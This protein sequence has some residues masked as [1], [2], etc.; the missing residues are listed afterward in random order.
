MLDFVRS[1]TGHIGSFHTVFSLKN[2]NNA[3][4]KVGVTLFITE[5]TFVTIHLTPYSCK[6]IQEDK[7]AR[8]EEK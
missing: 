3:L 5:H 1:Y 7:E 2:F 8:K 6:N 4:E